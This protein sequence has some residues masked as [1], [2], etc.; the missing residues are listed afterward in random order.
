MK[1]RLLILTIL[2]LHS[3]AYSQEDS[4]TSSS[5]LEK[6]KEIPRNFYQDLWFTD[7]TDNGIK[8]LKTS[9]TRI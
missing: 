5:K 4:L 3:N 9:S 8:N 2:A 6:N 7:K 1:T